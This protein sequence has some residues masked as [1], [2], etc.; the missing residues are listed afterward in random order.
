[1]Y[2]K[3]MEADIFNITTNNVYA[4]WKSE[5]CMLKGFEHMYQLHGQQLIA[6]YVLL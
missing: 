5:V 6:L 4:S 3:I 1:M 2:H